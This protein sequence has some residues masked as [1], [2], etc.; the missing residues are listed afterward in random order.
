M[1]LLDY[2]PIFTGNNCNNNCLN[3]EFYGQERKDRPLADIKKEI[4]SLSEIDNLMLCGGEPTIREDLLEIIKAAKNKGAK[5]IKLLTN[6]R[7]FSDI[8]AVVTATNSH[9]HHYDIKLLGGNPQQHDS[10]TG[11]SNS[12]SQ[13]IQGINNIKKY[14]LPNIGKSPFVQIRIGITKQNY[15]HLSSIVVSI[16]PLYVDRITLD[17]IDK[18]LNYTDI[19]KPVDDAIK[20][21]VF[22]KVWVETEKI[23]ACYLSGLEVHISEFYQKI[24]YNSGK[25]KN[26]KKC[27]INDYCPGIPEYL[28]KN[29]KITLT[30][31][32]E[33]PVSKSLKESTNLWKK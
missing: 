2:H 17:F 21:G 12:F 23:P 18:D 24:T 7:A 8:N 16:L 28:L 30:A 27:S 3:C 5:R 10:Q 29:E 6:G 11:I 14:T 13:T 31:L 19:F 32:K 15:L 9:V 20:T 25:Q 4:E 26:C 33:I 1:S 22:S